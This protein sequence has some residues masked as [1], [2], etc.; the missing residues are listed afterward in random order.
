VVVIAEPEELLPR[1]LYVVVGNNGV[2]YSKTM[3]DV[4]EE[5]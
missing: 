4:G 1:E 2:W 5:I 3:D